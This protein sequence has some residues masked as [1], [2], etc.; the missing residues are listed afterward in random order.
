AGES[1]PPSEGREPP[2]IATFRAQLAT[3]VDRGVAI[4]AAYS[5]IHRERY[6]HPDQLF[7]L[8]PELRGRVDRAYF[9]LANHTFTELDVQA[10]LIAAVTRW[11]STRFA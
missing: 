8:F 4:F 11:I 1:D 10:E 9:P 3:L 7:E 5:G 2:P 6:N